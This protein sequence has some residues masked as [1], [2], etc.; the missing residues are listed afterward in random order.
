MMDINE[1][2]AGID[3][4]D[5]EILALLIKRMQIVRQIGALKAKSGATIYR[6]EREKQSLDRLKVQLF[7]ECSALNEAK[8]KDI[9]AHNLGD[10]NL[11]LAINKSK[12]E[13]NPALIN[14]AL[15]SIFYEIFALS[16]SLEAP[17][18]VAFL[19]PLGTY[20]HEAAKSRFGSL[21]AYTPLSTIE[22]VFKEV[23]RGASDFGVV[24][25]ENNT[26]GAVNIT[27][28][29][30]KT[31]ENAK[32][33]AE[34]YLDIRHALASHESSLAKI[35][36][37]YSHPQAYAQ[38]RDFL[39]SHGLGEVEFV[40]CNSTANAASKAAQDKAAAAIC[41]R[42]AASLEALPILQASVQDNSA[43]RTRFF[44]LGRFK[45]VPSGSDK[46]SI[47]AHT[48]HKPGGLFE[49][50]G[51]FKGENINITKLE[52]R[53]IK[54]ESFKSMFYIDFEGHIDDE[55]VRRALDGARAS[56]H[57]V[58]FLG[59]YINQMI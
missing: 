35:K 54:R 6:P 57:E 18:K 3:S 29:C 5:D 11:E 41:S 7:N 47:L 20:S 43:N 8:N 9:K 31:Y 56:G 44:V 30:L 52:S 40:A 17:Q 32:I 2:R 45:N 26:E 23:Q 24:P 55:G 28:D 46:T 53:P 50:L 37:I 49:L 21:S 38:C 15:Q 33:V 51:L 25:I 36:R 39:S 16:R 27:L 48:P 59:S 42:V 58:R 12:N 22:A 1:L 34:I 13:L 4:I 10:K 19:G 14:P